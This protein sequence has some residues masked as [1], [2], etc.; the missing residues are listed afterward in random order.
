MR[1]LYYCNT[2]V[3]L[4]QSLKES[5][6]NDPA[7]IMPINEKEILQQLLQSLY[8]EY[9]SVTKKLPFYEENDSKYSILLNTQMKIVRAIQNCIAQLADPRR[10]FVSEKE[11]RKEFSKMMDKLTT[12][13]DI[14]VEKTQLLTYKGAS[15]PA[16]KRQLMMVKKKRAS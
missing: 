3:E 9:V 16:T 14:D 4:Q 1:K 11:W 12:S 15:I 7:S 8:Q 13:S 2:P 5:N 10:G 6:V